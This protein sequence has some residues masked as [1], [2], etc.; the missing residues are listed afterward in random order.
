[1]QCER[2]S[3]LLH[4]FADGELN[5]V[6]RWRVDRHIA[7]CGACAGRLAAS[8][9]VRDLASAGFPLIGGRLD[10]IEGHP[11]AAVVYQRR[12][13]VI[14]LF[15]WSSPGPDQPAHTAARQG[16]NVITW[17]QGDI[18]FAAVSDLD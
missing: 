2:A 17:R 12:Q 1:M 7:R 5:P 11:A 10:Y 9:P 8:P 13:H 18:A 4:P 16:F 14:N 3:G 15:A 6:T